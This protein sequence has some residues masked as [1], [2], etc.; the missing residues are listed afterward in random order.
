M[1]KLKSILYPPMVTESKQPLNEAS[2]L[3]NFKKVNSG[4]N[5]KKL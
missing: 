4:Y 5:P 1:I 2:F 3:D